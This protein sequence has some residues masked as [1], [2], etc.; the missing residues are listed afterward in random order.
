MIKIIEINYYIRYCFKYY[1]MARNELK[2]INKCYCISIN[3]LQLINKCYYIFN[4]IDD[5]IY[6]IMQLIVK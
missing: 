5:T 2:L 1:I 6:Y 3:L 4:S